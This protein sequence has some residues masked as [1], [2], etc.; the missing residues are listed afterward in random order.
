MERPPVFAVEDGAPH[1]APRLEIGCPPIRCHPTRSPPAS[2][3][4]VRGAADPHAERAVGGD[5]AQVE[6]L[7]HPRAPL[8]L[9]EH[10]VDACRW[11]GCKYPGMDRDPLVKPAPGA[12]PL[13]RRRCRIGVKAPADRPTADRPSRPDA[14]SAALPGARTRNGQLFLL[15]IDGGA[16]KTLAAVLDVERG[17]LHV[18]HGGPSNQDAVGVQAAGRGLFDAA[19]ESAREGPAHRGCLQPGRCGARGGGHGHGRGDRA[20]SRGA[21]GGVD[22]WW[23]TWWEHGRRRDRRAGPG[24]GAISGT[25]SNVFGR[26]LTDGRAWRAAGGWGHLLGDEGSGYWL[27]VQSIK[28]ALRDRERSGPHTALSDAAIEFFEVPSV[29]ALATKVYSKPLTKG[30][31]AAFAIETALLAE[32]GD[33]VARELYERGARELASQIAA[34]IHRTGLEGEFPVGL[35]GS[36]Y[37]AGAV[38]V[39]PLTRAIHAMAPEAQVAVVEMNPVGGSLLLAARACGAEGDADRDRSGGADRRGAGKRRSVAGRSHC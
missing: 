8:G 13:R 23:A 28:A 29:E 22:L 1:R 18:G 9:G 20:R 15:G 21:L 36:A 5:G 6:G 32:R 31:I 25:G 12:G 34:V 17:A 11:H 10:R 35:I 4:L 26:R 24:V 2:G 27:G 37:K 7:V 19:D 33:A 16:T 39:D 30:E 14:S 38:F 3:G